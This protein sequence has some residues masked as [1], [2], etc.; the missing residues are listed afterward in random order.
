MRARLSV[1]LLTGLAI[2]GCGSTSAPSGPP[3]GWHVVGHSL[4]PHLLNPRQLLTVGTGRLPAGG[5]CAQFPSAAL[6]AMRPADV[7][8][9]V[10]ERF[11]ES[12]A[13]PPRPARFALAPTRSEA[14]ECVGAHAVFV[15]H[16]SE[17]RDGGRGFHVL[18]AVGRAAPDAKVR[19]ALGVLDSLRVTP[20]RPARIDPD[21]AIPYDAHG[22]HLVLPEQWSVYRQPLTQA[23]SARDQLALG[24]FR[25]RQRSPDANCTPATALRARPSGGGFIFMFEM[26][27]I[28]R[29]NLA[30]MPP[31]P[32]HF[33][34]PAP[35]P[36]ECFGVGAQ[37]TFREHGRA[38]QAIVYGPGRRRREAV[39]ILDSLRIDPAR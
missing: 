35:E 14:E 4:T 37:V 28:P 7:L 20:R 8:V 25:L 34:L 16:W 17:F 18:V 36:L 2:A 6:A 11:G 19:E 32:D 26:R 22:L 39:T 15:S 29:L 3:A 13:F 27:G 10:Q 1:L 24:T 23:I 33:R 38:F 5:R 31:R 30:Q 21:L 9:A 12:T